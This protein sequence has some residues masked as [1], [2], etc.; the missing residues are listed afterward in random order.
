MVVTATEMKNNFGKYLEISQREDVYVTKNGKQVAKL[1]NLEEEHEALLDS[2]IGAFAPYGKPE[3][4]EDEK[5][6]RTDAVEEK[7]GCRR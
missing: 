5:S 4:W 6:A 1:V 2:L 3:D 7:H